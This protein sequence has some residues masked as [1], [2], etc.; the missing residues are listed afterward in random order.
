MS[1][2]F[3]TLLAAAVVIGIVA[4]VVMPAFN[5]ITFAITTALQ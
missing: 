3:L 1:E 4:F 5:Y 2:S